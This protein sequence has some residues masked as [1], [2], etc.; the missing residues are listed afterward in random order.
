MEKN[1][2]T[3]VNGEIITNFDAFFTIES[4]DETESTV[5][6]DETAYE[7]E[8]VNYDSSKVLKVTEKV[9]VTYKGVTGCCQQSRVDS[10]VQKAFNDWVKEKIYEY[11]H[12]RWIKAWA[13][14]TRIRCTQTRDIVT[15]KRRCVGRGT[16]Q[17]SITFRRL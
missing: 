11:R 9:N 7:S 10:E 16:I 5:T 14:P 1:N 6:L 8:N 13:P 4:T 15:G 12:L 17:A 3:D 2:E